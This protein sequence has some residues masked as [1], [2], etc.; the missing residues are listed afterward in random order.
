MNAT[1]ILDLLAEK[2]PPPEWAFLRE[3]RAGTGYT[4][5]RDRGRT[6]EADVER[7][8]DGWAINGYSSKRRQ[9]VAYEVKVSK[10]DFCRDVTKP[11]KRRAGLLLSNLFYYVAPAGVIAPDQVPPECGLLEVVQCPVGLRVKEAVSAPWRDTPPCPW[12]FVAALARRA[13]KFQEN[14]R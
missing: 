8:L 2:H 12:S 1:M 10:G 7:R 14:E 4:G 3:V 9:R 5:T 6:L 11:L 13:V